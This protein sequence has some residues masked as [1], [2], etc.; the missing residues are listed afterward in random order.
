MFPFTPVPTKK[1]RRAGRPAKSTT[2][3][4]KTYKRKSGKRKSGKGRRKRRH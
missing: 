2:R 1:R 3:K 4:R